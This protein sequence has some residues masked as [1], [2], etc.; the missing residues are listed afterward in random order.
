MRIVFAL[1]TALFAS[2]C[3]TI[4]GVDPARLDS[5]NKSLAA[6]T[7]RIEALALISTDLVTAGVITP[8]QGRAISTNLRTAL[9]AVQ[10]AKDAI[11]A[12]GDPTQAD[13]ALEIAE[14]SI[15]VTLRL[16]QSFAPKQTALF[17]REKSWKPLQSQKYFPA[18]SSSSGA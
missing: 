12:S 17:E 18:F 4:F 14:R 5:A 16:L 13:T 6:A 11:A 15:D 8:S 1:I 10:Q 7:V 9:D 3:A 2:S